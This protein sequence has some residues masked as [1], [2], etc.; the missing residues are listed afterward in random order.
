MPFPDR[1][2]SSF[3]PSTLKT[4]EA[5]KASLPTEVQSQVTNARTMLDAAK[6]GLATTNPLAAPK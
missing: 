4:L 3:S 1:F 2:R 6:K 5:N